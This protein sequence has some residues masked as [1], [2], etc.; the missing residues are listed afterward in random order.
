MRK[1]IVFSMA[2]SAIIN[3][4]CTK[5]IEFKGDYSKD[6]LVVNA[7][8][9]ADSTIVANVSHSVFFM[10]DYNGKET[11]VNDAYLEIFVNGSSI[12]TMTYQSHN[13]SNAIYTI[14]YSPKQGDKLELK[15][16]HKDYDD[17]RA[18]TEIPYSSTIISVDT[19]YT[20]GNY[21]NNRI[22]NLN[23][24]FQDAPE[25]SNYYEIKAELISWTKSY[26]SGKII[27]QV[28]PL[29]IY[30]NDIVFNNSSSSDPIFG[31]NFESQSLVFDDYIING[32][33]YTI[34]VL[35]D[36]TYHFNGNI[37]GYKDTLDV[38]LNSI[39]KD[40]Y[41]FQK[42]YTAY[43]NDIDFIGIFNEPVQ[44]Y[45]NVDGGIGVVAGIT[46]NKKVIPL[47]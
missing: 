47:N 40:Y 29:R 14:P 23:I 4:S 11:Y 31:T 30:S 46:I 22:I 36:N 44:I 39:S 45:N 9:I 28:I 12:G 7:L 13:T 32:K 24:K 10:N 6:K 34:K 35:S 27:R 5:E 15:A 16:R 17:V 42:T 18:V 2:I 41:M 3:F 26:D 33:E 1:L 20:S 38:C 37:D 25:I 19:S 21:D 8:L 43:T